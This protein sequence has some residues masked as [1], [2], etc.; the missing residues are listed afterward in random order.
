[1]KKQ[2]ITVFLILLLTRAYSGVFTVLVEAESFPDKGGWVVDQQFMDQMGSPYLMAHGLGEPVKNATTAIRFPEKGDF[3]VFVRTFNWTSPWYKG[4]GPGKFKLIIDG[5]FLPAILGATGNQWMWQDAG[6]IRINNAEVKLEL[7]DLTGFNGRCDA[8]IFTT[9]PDFV[10][11]MDMAS[12]KN[13]RKKLLGQ[14]EP[15]SL[16][17]Y[18]FVVTGGGVA[19]ICAAV[20]AARLGLKVAMINDRPVLGGNNSS[21]IRA[22][23]S[24]NT[25]KNLYPN[26]GNVLKEIN[27]VR[28]DNAGPPKGSLTLKKKR[29]LLLKKYRPVSE[30]ACY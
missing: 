5:K 13:L 20:S 29:W 15:V 28:P 16:N 4:E 12:M 25:D 1:M 7:N 14:I 27:P 19:G 10:P 24:G 2:L 22:G 26:I 9:D 11:P 17:S 23:L 8:I 6:K 21:E 18:D 30:Y 3:K